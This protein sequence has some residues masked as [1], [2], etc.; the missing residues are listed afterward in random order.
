VRLAELVGGVKDLIERAV[1]P[2]GQLRVER[3]DPASMS[4][5]D[6]LQLE[7]AI[8]NLAF[9]ARDAMPEGGTLTISAERRSGEVAPDLPARRLCRADGRR[10][11]ARA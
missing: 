2:L 1:A 11:P 4:K 3:I 9:N 10:I 6:P 5:S 7:L 8:L